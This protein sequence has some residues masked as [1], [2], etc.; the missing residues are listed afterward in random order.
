MKE[1]GYRFFLS[2]NHIWLT[3]EVPAQYLKKLQ[4]HDQMETCP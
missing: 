4:A 1:D 3:K 2:A